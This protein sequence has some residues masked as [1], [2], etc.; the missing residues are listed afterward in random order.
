M[1]YNVRDEDGTEYKIEEIEN[2]S[3]P[4]EENNSDNDL[5]R[6]EI[7]ALKKIASVA[8]ILIKL[9]SSNVTDNDT[10]EEELEEEID[11][12]DEEEEEEFEAKE[13]LINTEKCKSNDS[14]KKSAV[15][16]EKKVKT[17]DSDEDTIAIAWANRYGGQK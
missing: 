6:D 17:V 4:L 15:A 2:V 12:N 7:E 11:V 9:A 3:A 16:I 13:K 10:E 14:I 1:K 8:D 5:S